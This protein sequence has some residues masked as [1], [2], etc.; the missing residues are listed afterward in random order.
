VEGKERN[1][2]EVSNI[3]ILTG[4][5]Q[6]AKEDCPFSDRGKVK[7]YELGIECALDC[8]KTFEDLGGNQDGKAEI[9]SRERRE[10]MLDYIAEHDT[11]LIYLVERKDREGLDNFL[12]HMTEY[13]D[14]CMA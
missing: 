2:A 1:R 10:T 6:N 14:L 13:V 8:I 3:K 12:K 5:V 11:E 4:M 9:Y 7:A